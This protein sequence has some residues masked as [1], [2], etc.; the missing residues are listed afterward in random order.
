MRCGT[1]DMGSVRAKELG[2]VARVS[3]E[4]KNLNDWQLNSSGFS[5]CSNEVSDYSSV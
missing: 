5:I 3:N 4:K 1:D 2:G